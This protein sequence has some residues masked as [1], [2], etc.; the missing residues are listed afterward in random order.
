MDDPGL[1]WHLRIPDLMVEQGGFVY[2][3]YFSFPSEGNRWVTRAWLSDFCMRAAYGWGGL[4][5]I[6]ILTSLVFALTL[7]LIY[8]RIVQN[9]MHWLAAAAVTYFG[10]LTIVPSFLA[11]PNIA[12]FL[13]IWLVA[14]LLTQFHAGKLKRKQLAW[15]VPIMLLWTNMHGSFMAGLVLIGIA[16]AVEAALSIASSKRD[17]RQE[18]GKRVFAL[19]MFGAVAG[20]A[21]LVNPNGIGLHLYNLS[22]VTDTFIQNNSTKEWL[23]PDFRLSGFFKIEVLI[24]A[25]PL[26]AATCRK[27]FNF[28]GLVLTVAWLHFAL[29]GRR[30][31][32]LWVV[33]ALPTLCELALGNPWLT[34]TLKRLQ[35]DMSDEVREFFKTIGKWT[36]SSTDSHDGLSGK[37]SWIFAAGALLIAGLIPQFANHHPQHIPSA[38]LEKFLETYDGGRTFHDVNWGGYLTWKGWNHSN[39]FHT[40]IDDRIEVHG[41][42]HL[43]DYYKIIRGEDGWQEIL[44]SSGVQYICVGKDSMLANA[45]EASEDWKCEFKDSY[46]AVFENCYFE[47]E[48]TDGEYQAF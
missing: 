47:A 8:S 46:I 9:G 48:A 42:E 24:L 35:K 41:A 40:W 16:W 4:N 28:L 7:R 43:K 2:E 17:R 6:A 30:Y 33:I 12:A 19:T 18:A 10:L 13:G 5:G 21:T 44:I 32:T 11:R 38:S 1:G 3:E 36:G 15:L 23:P 29:T 34:R 37:V 27:R 25:L 45:A 14:D 22:A 39:R 20:L 26:L 31:S